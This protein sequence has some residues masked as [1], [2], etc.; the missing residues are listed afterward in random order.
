MIL[1]K[2]VKNRIFPIAQQYD[3]IE[4]EWSHEYKDGL[5]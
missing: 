2:K 5:D 3:M 1:E 4:M